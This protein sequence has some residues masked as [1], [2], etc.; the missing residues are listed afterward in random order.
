MSRQNL[1]II[2]ILFIICLGTFFHMLRNIRS[3]P[4]FIWSIYG[5]NAEIHGLWLVRSLIQTQ[6][7]ENPVSLGFYALILITN[8][9]EPYQLETITA[10]KYIFR[11][12]NKN[13]KYK[14]KKH[15]KQKIRTLDHIDKYIT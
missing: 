4:D 13:V 3:I 11:V 14:N 15:E 10:D 7:R 2:Q 1:L 8:C 5:L 9:F 12:I 6:V